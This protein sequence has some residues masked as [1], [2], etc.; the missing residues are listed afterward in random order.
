MKTEKTSNG[1]EKNTFEGETVL[2]TSRVNGLYTCR[3]TAQ[4]LEKIE[5]GQGHE[6]IML[7]IKNN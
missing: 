6:E 5:Q 4:V 1:F 7:M 2:A 3:K